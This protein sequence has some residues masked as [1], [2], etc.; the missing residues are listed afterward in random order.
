VSD[1]RRASPPEPVRRGFDVSLVGMDGIGK[2]TLAGALVEALRRFG[3]VERVTWEEAIRREPP[4]FVVDGLQELGLSAYRTLYGGVA[5]ADLDIHGTFPATWGEF[6]R[7]GYEER[8]S[9]LRVL[10]NE[11]RGVVASAFVEAAGNL[12]LWAHVIDP[13]LDAGTIV[14]QESYGLKH[15]LRELLMAR[16]LALLQGDEG[17]A[18]TISQL[19]PV[20]EAAFLRFVPPRVGVLVTGEPELAFRWRSGQPNYVGIAEDLTTIGVAGE[21]SFIDFQRE[22][23]LE[24]EEVAR[25]AGWVVV[26][27]ADRAKEE[28]VDAAV[29]AILEHL[30]RQGLVERAAGAA[31]E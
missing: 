27:M 7:S 13:K 19:M 31:A 14:V 23:A 28:N 9:R 20:V 11:L 29:D 8:L 12:F 16:R 15:A 3:P 26:R 24:F 6:E 21:D 10:D 22:C 2:T 17:A 30:D 5:S 18:D 25:R 1:D 4:G